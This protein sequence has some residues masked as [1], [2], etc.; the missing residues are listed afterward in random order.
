MVQPCRGEIANHQ[1][2]CGF[3]ALQRYRELHEVRGSRALRCAKLARMRLYRGVCVDPRD[4]RIAHLQC[5]L[6]LKLQ[7]EDLNDHGLEVTIDK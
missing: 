7:I 2:L 5:S 3:S 1:C 4:F 6:L